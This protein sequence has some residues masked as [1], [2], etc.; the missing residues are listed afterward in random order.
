MKKKIILTTVVIGI[1]FL[2]LTIFYRN[3]QEKPIEVIFFCQNG[4]SIE[5]KFYNK[6]KLVKLVLSDGRK[7]EVPQTISA[8]GA[9]YA[10]TDESLVFWNKGN[11]AF[12]EENGKTVYEDCWTKD[13]SPTET[14]ESNKTGMANPAS[15]N[16]SSKGGQLKIETRPDGGQYGLCFFDDNRACEEWAMFR[17]ECPVGG[18]KTTGYDTEAQKYCAWSGGQTIAVENAICTFSNGST[19]PDEA[20]YAG[21]CQKK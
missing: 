4:S 13:S 16:C 20:F 2:G 10:N 11:S 5:A 7:M 1:L 12:I 17:G 21:T 15:I 18:R 14:P 9:R 19:C 8:S 3:N 6:T